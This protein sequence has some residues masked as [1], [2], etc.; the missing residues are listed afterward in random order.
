MK[1]LIMEMI[2]IY[3]DQKALLLTNSATDEISNGGFTQAVLKKG[4]G[5]EICEEALSDLKI[6]GM[7]KVIIETPD[8]MV[9]LDELKADFKVIKAAGGF[10]YTDER[11]ALFIFRRGKWDLPKG[12]LDEGET[13]EACA[14]REVQEETGIQQ[15]SLGEALL[16]TY[17]TYVE[18]GELVLK[19]SHWYLMH[20]AD[21]SVLTPQTEEDIE[22]CKWVP[23]N[24]MKN[25][26]SNT[27]LSII[28]V[29]EKAREKLK[30]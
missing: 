26:L 2:K 5:K 14:V 18:R 21:T 1:P 16:I 20:S 8:P 12:K 9:M 11:K 29:V 24:E 22:E 30:G 7:E 15:L 23:F 25:Y 4:S 19:E 27:H 10:V 13:L 3:F 28:D 17:H 6:N